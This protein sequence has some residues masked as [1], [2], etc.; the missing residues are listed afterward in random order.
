MQNVDEFKEIVNA[1]RTVYVNSAKKYAEE[2]KEEMD[3]SGFTLGIETKNSN[4]EEYDLEL[5]FDQGL[6]S[7]KIEMFTHGIFIGGSI[8]I[9]Y[10]EIAI[11]SEI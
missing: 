3:Y 5:A 6:D 7:T 2:R 1:F 8:Y 11:L 4:V 10:N 9:P